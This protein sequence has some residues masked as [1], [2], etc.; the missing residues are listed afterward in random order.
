M[1]DRE[2]VEKAFSMQTPEAV[3]DAMEEELKANE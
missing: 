2:L 1:T 3:F